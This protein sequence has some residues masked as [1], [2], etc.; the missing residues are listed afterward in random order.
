[1]SGCVT[2]SSNDDYDRTINSHADRYA[3][4]LDPE[5]AR[6]ELYDMEPTPEVLLTDVLVSYCP[7]CGRKL[8]VEETE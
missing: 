4:L 8:G 5:H 2:C 3:L 1:M 7:I 6:I